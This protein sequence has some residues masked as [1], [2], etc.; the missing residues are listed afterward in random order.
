[1][2]LLYRGLSA[3]AGMAGGLVAGAVFKK[4]WQLVRHEPEPPE[5]TDRQRS[6]GEVLAAACLQGATFG[7][8]KA[9]VDR[10]AAR[11]FAGATGEWPA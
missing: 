10:A 1:M 11:G 4:L 6:W 9:A 3:L 8:I 2:R 5:A 7:L